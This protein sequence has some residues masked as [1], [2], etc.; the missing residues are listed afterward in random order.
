MPEVLPARCGCD[1]EKLNSNQPVPQNSASVYST[2]HQPWAL[3]YARQMRERFGI[4]VWVDG[5]VT[6]GWNILVHA[7]DYGRGRRMFLAVI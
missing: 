1:A 6:R 2:L 7:P 4:N 3:K 5:T